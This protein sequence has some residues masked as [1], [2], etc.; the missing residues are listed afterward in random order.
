[1]SKSLIILVLCNC[2][3]V[4]WS[5]VEGVKSQPAANAE[6][7]ILSCEKSG[8]ESE[9][10]TSYVIRHL[11]GETAK[12]QEQWRRRR[13]LVES[14]IWQTAFQ[15]ADTLL[16]FHARRDTLSTGLSEEEIKEIQPEEDVVGEIVRKEETG[17][18]PLFD[19][20]EAISR[21]LKALGGEH[22]V[23]NYSF[24]LN[25]LIPSAQEIRIIK[26]VWQKGPATS[27]E[28]YAALDSIPV[29]M[30]DVQRTLEE[31]TSRGYFKRIQVSPK[32]EF[33]LFGVAGIEL[34]GKNA[35]NREYLY[36]PLIDRQ[37]L[38]AF[39]DAAKYARQRRNNTGDDLVA[40]HFNKLMTMLI[41]TDID[42]PRP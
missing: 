5:Q 37:H 3:I 11:R 41:D 9:D 42:V 26:V 16:N 7:K 8:S 38:L 19:V 20:S 1:M 31:M 6:L 28:I 15:V 27:T 18:P 23:G 32:H 13:A 10:S 33:S 29:T 2:A 4:A 24:D 36:F 34:S 39:L 40:N 17:V 22:G 21:G 25:S 14:L 35:R 12:A 30:T